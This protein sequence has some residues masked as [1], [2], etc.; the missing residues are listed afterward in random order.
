MEVK[1]GSKMS[2]WPKI[3]QRYDQWPWR[4]S[5]KFCSFNLE[6]KIAKVVQVEIIQTW[7][8][9][10]YNLFLTWLVFISQNTDLVYIPIYSPLKPSFFSPSNIY[11]TFFSQLFKS[12]LDVAIG[13]LNNQLCWHFLYRFD[14]SNDFVEKIKSTIEN[15]QKNNCQTK[16]I[17]LN[18]LKFC[19]QCIAWSKQPPFSWSLGYLVAKTHMERVY[20]FCYVCCCKRYW[21]RN[22]HWSNFKI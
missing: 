13:S 21:K 6:I 15:H 18:S 12:W 14:K 3:L 9:D 19:L 2:H 22:P 4:N 20:I 17:W 8:F 5:F 11:L 16:K 10:F 1:L 7:V